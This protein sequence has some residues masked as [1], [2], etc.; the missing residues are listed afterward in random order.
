MAFHGSQ[1]PEMGLP[2]M[3]Q[4]RA[5]FGY[6]G[7]VIALLATLFSFFGFNVVNVSLIMDGLNHVFGLPPAGVAVIA[8]LLGAVL[9]IYG[10][11]AMHKAF[12]WAIILTIPLYALVTASLVFG[13]GHGVSTPRTQLGFNWV[14]FIS[15]F[16]I[17]ASYN[18][19]VAPYISDY[20]R[21][22]PKNTNRGKLILIISLGASFSAIWMIGLGAWLAQKLGAS[23]ALVALN[24]VGSSLIP[25]LGNLIVI[26]SV[27]GFVPVIALNT[28]SAMLTLLTGVDS[29]IKIKPTRRA[30]IAAVIVISVTLAIVNMSLKGAGV[31]LVNTFLAVLLYFLVPWTAVN[32]IDYFFVRKRRYAIAHFF[33]PNGMYGAWNARG[34]AAYLIGFGAMV[35]FFSIVDA[36]TD[37]EIFV[38]YFA[39]LMHGIDIAWLVGLIVS[40]SV[41]FLM[42]ISIDLKEEEKMI[43][44]SEKEN[45]NL[46]F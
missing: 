43:S 21:Y 1:G 17:G 18:I 40:G 23:D 31:A 14:A 39:H 4:S 10:Y 2:Q 7:V 34:I 29:F 22:L 25:G 30:R 28:Y 13:N 15:Q 26:A 37:K 24:Q 27:I 44:E 11:H 20:T 41:Y 42:S 45:P 19:S 16:A 9:A 5:Q 3:I 33:K 12:T 36:D 8:A 32:L 35:P 46:S 6:R 38:G